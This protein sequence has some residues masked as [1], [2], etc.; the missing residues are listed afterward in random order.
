LREGKEGR[1]ERRSGKKLALKEPWE[2]NGAKSWPGPFKRND[3]II[4]WDT[5][6]TAE[7][8]KEFICLRDTVP[9]R[10]IRGGRTSA[11]LTNEN[12]ATECNCEWFVCLDW[13]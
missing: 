3:Q 1:K 2:I 8:P 4:I 12:W 11:K 6:T 13:I 9:W 7:D 5:E 10:G